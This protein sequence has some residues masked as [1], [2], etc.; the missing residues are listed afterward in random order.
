MPAGARQNLKDF[1][2]E[3]QTKQ[4][5]VRHGRT[6]GSFNRRTTFR[7]PAVVDARSQSLELYHSPL[8]RL[9]LDAKLVAQT[10]QFLPPGRRAW[11]YKEKISAEDFQPMVARVDQ[12]LNPD[13]SIQILDRTPTNNRGYQEVPTR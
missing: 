1:F 4:A 3:I 2:A 9:E 5:Q 7:R 6:N 12:T 8:D 13:T 11:L 10:F